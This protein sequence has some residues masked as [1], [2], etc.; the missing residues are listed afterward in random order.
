M[1]K[2]EAYE[3]F[4]GFV[5][6]KR[7]DRKASEKFLESIS[8]EAL[9]DLP[10]LCYEF[11]A[12]RNCGNSLILSFGLVHVYTTEGN[13]VSMLA[14]FQGLKSYR[15]YAAMYDEGGYMKFSM[16]EQS[17]LAGYTGSFISQSQNT[18][19][20]FVYRGQPIYLVDPYGEHGKVKYLRE[21]IY[22]KLLFQPFGNNKG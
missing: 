4:R 22:D 9:S 3:L 21:D 11:A 16:P 5:V 8:G 18:V 10:R 2:K 1:N 15:E 20:D 6:G 13:S 7:I 17:I 14:K 19:F 12:D